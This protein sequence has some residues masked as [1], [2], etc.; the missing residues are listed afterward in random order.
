MV[1]D[2]STEMANSLVIV[3][4]PAKAKTIE[5]FLGKGFRVKACL[6]HIKD[7]P[8]R[9][10]GID[11]D[12]GYL[13]KYVTIK[14]KGKMIREL[15]E[16]AKGVGKI[17]LATDPDREGEAIGWQVDRTI[18]SGQKGSHRLLFNEIT[19]KTVQA[20][21]ENPTQID[22]KKV[23]AQQAR[24]VLDRLVGYQVSPLL[25]KT[26]HRGLSAGRVQSV[27]LRL[28]CEREQGIA[29]FIPEEYW[30]ITAEL[31]TQR[32][33]PFKAK[34]VSVGSKRIKIPDERKAKEIVQDL[35]GREYVVW[36]IKKREAKKN[37]QPPFITSTLQ[38]EV[39]K[40]FRFSAT[41]TMAIAQQ[42]YEGLEIG[43]EGGVGL[44]TYMR[45]DSTRTAEEA[46]TEVREY[47]LGSYGLDYLPQKPIVYKSRKGAQEAH[48]AIR[49]TSMSRL[50]KKVKKF[51]T[52]DQFLLYELIWNRFVASQMKPAIY[53]VTVVEVKA[54]GYLFRAQGS[55][56]KFRGFTVAY[57]EAG[58]EAEEGEQRLPKLL[59]VGEQLRLLGLFPQ[60]HFTKPPPRYTEASLVKELEAKGI[61]R[62]STYAQIIDTL[63]NRKYVATEDRRFVATDLGMTV[64]RILVKNFPDIFEVGFTARMEEELDKIEAG[65]ANWVRV[66]DNFY[67]PFQG[68]LGEAEAKETELR[69]SAQEWTEERCEKCGRPM[70][71][72]WGRHGRFMGCSGFPACRNTKPLPEEAEAS[73]LVEERCEKCGG[74]MVIKTGRYGRFLACSNYPRCENTRPISTGIDCPEAGCDGY[75]TERRTKRG[76]IFYGCSRYPQCTYAIWDKPVAKH[77]PQCGVKFLVERSTKAKGK[78]LKCLDCKGEFKPDE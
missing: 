49:P 51:L 9:E 63:K 30:S 44:I 10:L 32:G 57:E 25:W 5:K 54:D 22:M 19:K 66:V 71:I 24:R 50:P 73:R 53:E 68:A 69:E 76:K 59:N 67:Q 1:E 3:E 33:D 16:A 41:K 38:Q 64:N 75:L 20:A 2:G 43:D 78:L 65:Q 37:P 21:V 72:R 70:V 23:N 77:C 4:S 6:G 28:I 56:V 31:Q 60:Q 27:A 62:P 42:L 15:K 55:V 58:E 47:I 12:H 17:Y 26:V 8:K 34:L 36:D 61:G 13:P 14:G 48:E 45:T 29:S 11:L 40:K 46:L 35:E 7:L 39:A 74:Q 18:N 52:E